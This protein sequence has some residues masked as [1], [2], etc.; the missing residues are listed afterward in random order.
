MLAVLLFLFIAIFISTSLIWMLDHNGLVVITWLG[1]EV[2][3][4]ILTALLLTVFFALLLFA[5]SYLLARILAIKFPNLLKLFSKKNYLRRLEKLLKRH[6]QAFDVMT[7]LLLSLETHDKKS[8]EELHKKFSK[9]IKVNNLNNFFLGKIFLEKREFSKAITYFSQLGENKHAKILVLKSKLELSLKNQEEVAAIAYAKQILSVKRDNFDTAK[10]L[11]SLYKKCGLWQE[12]KG[13]IAEYGSDQFK[14]ELQRRDI[15]VINTA[16]ALEAYQQ[17]K[18]LLAIKH[19]RLALKAENNFL[20]AIEIT[21]KSW[22][23]LGFVFTTRWK[24]KSLWN[25]NP[26]LIFAEIF[27]ATHRKSGSKNRIKAMKKLVGQDGE[28]YLAKLAIGEVAYRVGSY[29]TAKEF[30]QLSL[31]REKNYRTYRLLAYAEKALGNY[32]EFRNNL[33]KA[34]MLSKDDHYICNSCGHLSTKWSAKCIACGSYDSLE[35]NF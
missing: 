12:A 10:T 6:Q 3:T 4:D 14:D 32:E 19:A 9:L 33:A 5:F 20:P 21:L 28:S 24:I 1:Y 2:K 11:F 27:D 35:W 7:Q 18:F 31:I 8:Y 29:S 25:E 22:L 23:K 26:H 16:L 17:K 34:K 15:A 30:L 13:L